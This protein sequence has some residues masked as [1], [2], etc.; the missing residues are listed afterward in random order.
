MY[1][2]VDGW[3]GGWIAMHT[4]PLHTAVLILTLR[5]DI[6]WCRLKGEGEVKDMPLGH[7]VH[8]PRVSATEEGRGGN[9]KKE[10]AILGSRKGA[11]EG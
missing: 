2:C 8:V 3:V 5:G 6:L 9:D 4:N 7:F 10:F 1:G 11:N